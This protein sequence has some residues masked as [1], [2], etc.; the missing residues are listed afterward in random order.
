M[1]IFRGLDRPPRSADLHE[2][3][4]FAELLCLINP[5][6]QVTRADLIARVGYAKDMATD[7]EAASPET[8]VPSAAGDGDLP[9]VSDYWHRRADDTFRHLEYR[10]RAFGSSYAF[11]L[12]TS[13]AGDILCQRTP[14][15]DPQKLYVLLLICAN[16]GYVEPAVRNDLTTAFELVAATALRLLLPAS[17]EVHHF[18]PRHAAS[19]YTGLLFAKIKKLAEDLNERLTAHPEDFKAGDTGDGG[20]DLVGWVPPLD[21]EPSRVLIFGQ[22]ACGDE[23]VTKQHSSGSETWGARIAFRVFPRNMIFIPILFRDTSGHWLSS[24]KLRQSVLYD[25][26]RIMS[27]LST[28]PAAVVPV[29]IEPLLAQA[30]QEVEAA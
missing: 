9:E 17:G 26:L 23:W 3:A 21:E 11:E 7:T 28:T 13:S 8:E 19:R 5:D 20:L 18:G 29:P 30:L 24:D 25:R 27:V 2:W 6:S 4:D 14:F 15:T 12:R 16:L 22:C 1:A 10:V